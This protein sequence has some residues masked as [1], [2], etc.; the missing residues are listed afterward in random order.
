MKKYFLLS[1]VL[2]SLFGCAKLDVTPE[3]AFTPDNFYGNLNDATAAV[4]AVYDPLGTNDFYWQNIPSLQDQSTDDAEWGGGRSTANTSK[5]ELDRY[6]FTPSTITF[7]QVWTRCYQGINRAN[8]VIDRISGISGNEDLK[9]RLVGEA[10][11]A[12]AFYYFS[13]VRLYGGVPLSTSETKELNNLARPRASVD[14]VYQRI[15]TDFSDAETALP[16][17]YA[18]S[19]V[20]R[21]TQGAAKALLAKVYLT[22]GEW[23]AASAKCKEVIDL[24][25]YDL[26]ANY[27][28]VFLLANENGKESIFEVQAIS[29]GLN[30]GSA[31]QGYF[32]PSFDRAGFGDNPVTR[33]HYEAYP[34][35]DKRRDVNTRL[36]SRT[37]APIAPNA[38]AYPCYVAKY[39]DPTATSNNDGANNFPVVRYAD[40]LLMYAEALNEQG[41]GTANAYAAVNR[42]RRRAG[43]ADL[44]GLTQGQFRDAILLERRLELAF[45]GHRWY[46]LVRTGRLISAVRAQNATIPVQPYH[47]LFPIPQTERDVNPLLDQ[48]PDY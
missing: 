45:E 41:T 13:L 9:T 40:V 5:N 21:A 34:T 22:R 10:K 19:D 36:Y 48:N 11:F 20:G 46:D 32:R 44:G 12:R 14:E 1:T 3:S 18:G 43:L 37:T 6:T 35:G 2:A 38:I 4:N 31:M 24:G 25:V 33:N 16:L 8:A 17:R 30:E 23:T 26:W 28:D 47:V 39:Q 7:F 15:I 42:L 27:G 29:G